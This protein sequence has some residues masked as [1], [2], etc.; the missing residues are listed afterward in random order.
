AGDHGGSLDE[1]R[2]GVLVDLTACVGCRRCEWACCEANG[3]P[4]GPLHEYDDQ[5]VFEDRRY[6][7]PDSL[8]VVNRE[9]HAGG[10]GRDPVH[11]KV[12][13]MHC[14][15]PACVSACLVGA[16]QKDPSGPVH[17]DA[18]RCI[19]CRYCMVACPFEILTYEYDRKVTPRVRKCEL[20]SERTA[21][22]G[23]PACVEMCPVEALTY[24]RRTDLIALAHDRIADHPERYV[25]HVYGET[26]AGGTSWLYIAGKPFE[27]LGFPTLAHTSPAAM[28]EAIQHGIFRGFAAPMVVGGL[29]AAVYGLTREDGKA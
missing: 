25:D 6:P 14:E 23:L 2:M 17:Y 4:H 27:Q 10:A 24:G 15:K 5:S 12:Q 28:S 29:L 9:K 21:Q 19:G 11:L 26:E 18:S 16:M 13:C 22:G 1:N 8:T 7:S 20:C 3:L